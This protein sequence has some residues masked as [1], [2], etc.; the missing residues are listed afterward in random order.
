MTEELHAGGS[1]TFSIQGTRTTQPGTVPRS[2]TEMKG[3]GRGIIVL[4]HTVQA[5]IN[6]GTPQGAQAAVKAHPTQRN[7]DAHGRFEVYYTH[8]GF[9]FHGTLAV[10]RNTSLKP[11]ECSTNC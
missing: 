7:K 9:S 2:A 6:Y 4:Y 1:Q 3:I 5:L 10:P 11:C 8:R